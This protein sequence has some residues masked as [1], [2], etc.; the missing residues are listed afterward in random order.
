[1]NAMQDKYGRGRHPGRLISYKDRKIIE[2]IA[3]IIVKNEVNPE[4]F[5]KS[6]VHA[7]KKKT[8]NCGDIR[9][10][11]RQELKNSVNFYFSKNEKMIAQFSIPIKFLKGKIPLEEY[12]KK[13]SEK[14]KTKKVSKPKIKDLKYGM[15]RFKIEGKVLEIPKPNVVYTRS[16][17][18]AFISNALIGD[19]TG[20]IRMSLWNDQIDKVSKGDNIR[21]EN[22]LVTNF[23]GELQLRIGRR[24]R[25][26]VVNE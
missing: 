26:S 13:I 25:L 8:A 22:G 6:I 24:G 10:L 5:F 17:T 7:W 4:E 14:M 20:T 1:M 18:Q 19:E 9:I 23:R 11:R 3:L 12:I 2:Y 16:G 15:K 21:I